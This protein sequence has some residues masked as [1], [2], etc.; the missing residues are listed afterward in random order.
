MSSATQTSGFI[1]GG[2]LIRF[3]PTSGIQ[4]ESL[5]ID[6]AWLAGAELVIVRAT[7]EGSVQRE[8]EMSDFDVRGRT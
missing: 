7:R 2:L 4:G 5:P 8:L 6:E 3:S 1:A